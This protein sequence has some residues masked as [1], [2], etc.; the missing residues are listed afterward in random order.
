MSIDI[1]WVAKYLMQSDEWVK[2]VL[3]GGLLA[4]FSF[5]V[6]P[7]FLLYGYVIRVLRA[8]MSGAQEPP[9]FDDWGTLLKEGVVGFVV[10]VIYQLIPLI[11]GFVT[12]GGSIAAMAA[13]GR[14]G[15]GVGVAGLF[16]GLALTTLLALVFGYVGLV[17][18]ANY[19]HTGSFGA[20]FDFDVI[21]SVATDGDYAI[22]W[23]YGVGCLIVGAVVAGILG[24]V[25]IIGAIVGVFVTFYAQVAASW[26]WGKGLRRRRRRLRH[27]RR[28]DRWR[29]ALRR[30]VVT[31]VGPRPVVGDRQTVATAGTTPGVSGN[32]NPETRCRRG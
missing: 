24:M 19:A 11:V 32:Q 25:P 10:V 5:L 3:I 29:D 28:D 1:S 22:P 9:V 30:S 6:I 31:S 14:A 18:L 20:A 17:G 23:L 16:G 21:T 12:V 26:L 15:A 8:G 2:T 13:G 4:L 7:A 27:R